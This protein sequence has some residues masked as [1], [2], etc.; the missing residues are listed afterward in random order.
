M[1]AMLVGAAGAQIEERADVAT[2]L[3]DLQHATSWSRQAECARA[4]AATRVPDVEVLAALLRHITTSSVPALR[5]ECLDA[6]ATLRRTAVQDLLAAVGR[7]DFGVVDH[8][9]DALERLGDRATSVLVDE[10]QKTGPAAG[11]ATTVLLR[12]GWLDVPELE[13]AGLHELAERALFAGALHRCAGAQE[14]QRLQAK[15][16]RA[17]VPTKRVPDLEWV[18]GFG[19]GSGIELCRAVEA[20]QGLQVTS[21]ALHEPRNGPTVA[22]VQTTLLPREAT[23]ALARQ[24]AIL[25]CI[26]WVPVPMDTRQEQFRWWMSTGNFVALVRATVGDDVLFDAAFCGYPA[27]D[28]VAQRFVP[29]VACKVLAESLRDARWETR[30]PTDADR[31]FVAAIGPRLPASQSWWTG[32]RLKKL[33]ELLAPR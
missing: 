25:P 11:V 24:L 10:V 19:H 3:H 5:A 2:L 8:A 18:G 23:S 14:S 30:E 15:L 20:E 7:G 1:L 32:K 28:N 26:E 27:G 13:R 22:V 9:V 12:R 4:L 29:E 31:T 16:A 6:Y 17:P 33:G 21:V